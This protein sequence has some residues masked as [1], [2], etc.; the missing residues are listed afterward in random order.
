MTSLPFSLEILLINTCFI[1]GTI[2][3]SLCKIRWIDCLSF[4][5]LMILDIG[6]LI[7]LFSNFLLIQNY[8]FVLFTVFLTSFGLAKLNPK[9]YA[10]I[11][12]AADE[13]IVG[14]VVG[15]LGSLVTAAVPIGSVGL[16]VLYNSVSPD[17]AYLTAIALLIVG[18]TTLIFDK[19]NVSPDR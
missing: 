18:M 12:E 2:F 14:T 8:W 10:Q 1:L 13:K 7:F 17:F 9:L 15:T 5:C 4:K 6:L 16:V 11:I 19:R 3:G